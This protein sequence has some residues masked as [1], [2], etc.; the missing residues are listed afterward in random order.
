MRTAVTLPPP[1]QAP[2]PIP[3]NIVAMS[4]LATISLAFPFYTTYIALPRMMVSMRVNLETI[5]WVLTGFSMAQT[6]MMPMVGWLS[7]R[8]GVRYVYT[9]CL[10]LTILGSLG[11]GFAWNA[12]TLIAWRIVQGLGSG[13][14]SPLSTVIMFDT[15]PPERRGMALGLL[16]TYWALGALIAL[17]LGGYLIETLSWRAIFFC[18]IPCGVLS[19][20]MAL[21]ALPHDS[22]E[23]SP[24]QLDV[25]GVVAMIG[26]LVPLLLAL[27]QGQRL[28]WD[29]TLIRGCWVVAASAAVAFLI[30][31]YTCDTP[32]IDLRLFRNVSFAMTCV[33]RFLNHIGFNAYSLLIALY[34]QTTLDY[35]PLRA[36]LVV[37]PSALVVAPASLWIGR[38]TDRLPPRVM[39][40]SGLGSLATGM[41]LFATVN[42]WTPTAW[43][44]GLVMLLRVSSEFLFAPL[45]YTGLRLLP[46]SATRMGSG[47]LSLMWSI[48]GTL[49]NV[50]TAVALQYRR[51][52]HGYTLGQEWPSELGERGEV[53]SEIRRLLS[54]AGYTA[55]SLEIATQEF[56]Q[57]YLQHE[58]SIA[59][60]QDCFL[61]AGV[62]FLGTMLPTLLIRLGTAPATPDSQR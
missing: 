39:L 25:W 41:A 17:P 7:N 28:G 14:I 34:L 19:L 27:S 1:I 26:C 2:L 45:N 30:R 58:V 43:I 21:R 55:D 5:Q 32:L 42:P 51:V 8:F 61:L 54:E 46:S 12:G 16:S 9:A 31:E 48:G 22:V 3:W 11:C 56:L 33:V 36:G 53:L 40:L 57:Q 59:A 50:V 49:G 37:L 15:F 13:P 52:I 47:I 60:Y 10:L 6:L 62:V 23:A 29:A 20:V 4:I 38:L 44:V 18:G 35:S 24:R